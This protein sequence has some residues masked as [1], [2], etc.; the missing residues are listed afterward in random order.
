MRFTFKRIFYFFVFSSISF[1]PALA[2]ADSLLDIYKLALENDKLMDASRATYNSISEYENQA[3][4]VLLPQLNAGS[5]YSRYNQEVTTDSLN[6]KSSVDNEFNFND[7]NIGLSQKLFDLSA[8]YNLKS[9]RQLTKQAKSEL[10][11]EIQHQ[12]IRVAQA[13]FLVL[14]CS[15]NLEVSKSEEKANQEQLARTKALHKGGF[16]TVTDVYEAQAAHDAGIAQRISDEASLSAAYEALSV[17]TN[18]PHKNL[19]TL[20]KDFPISRLGP[21]EPLSWVQLALTHN[22]SLKAAI[23]AVEAARESE[24]SKLSQH[25]PTVTGSLSYRNEVRNGTQSTSILPH[26]IASFDADSNAKIASIQISIPLFSGGYTRSQAREAAEKYNLSLDQK[27]QAERTLIQSVKS[28]YI[29]VSS[30]IEKINARFQAIASAD[31]ALTANKE[32]YK[33]GTR[34]FVDVL[35]AQRALFASRRDYTNAR[36]DYILN[37]FYLKELAGIISPTDIYELNEWLVSSD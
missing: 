31:M 10:I 9:G 8:W 20:S 24:R 14:R 34:N 4:A 13:Y 21:M 35:Q 23:Y 36:Y 16:S 27:I 12:I 33:I 7:W 5:S 2:R 30:D 22:N 15:D 29:D 19:N 6:S 1:S 18:R 32:S 3:R 11:Y 25:A 17:L 37:V 26:S 28:K